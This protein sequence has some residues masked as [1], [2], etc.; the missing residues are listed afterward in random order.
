MSPLRSFVRTLPPSVFA[1]VMATGAISIGAELAGWRAISLVLWGIAGVAWLLL[2][3]LLGIRVFA[4]ARDAL[5]DLDD[6]E[7]GF[8]FFTVVA[9][10]A[11]LG[12][13]TAMAGFTVAAVVLGVLALALWIVLGYGIPW[14]I[15]AS[16][17]RLDEAASSSRGADLVRSV[18]GLWF[19]WVVAAQSVAILATLL[20]PP[21]GTAASVIGL[22]ALIC[23]ATGLG[24]YFVVGGA[25][26]L[27]VLRYGIRADELGPAS[28]VVMGGLAISALA[29]SHLASA[30]GATLDALRPVA[31]GTALTLW[32]C[33]TAIIPALIVLGVWR[34]VV[35]RVSV[36]YTT[37]LWA[38]IFPMGVYSAASLTLGGQ[39]GEPILVQIGVVGVGIALASWVVVCLDFALT[40]ARRT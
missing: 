35:R 39:L 30:H 3:V 28:W 14:R 38:M 6:P 24:L 5:R 17:H 9:A 7:R 31:V 34:H 21:A 8:G 26:A 33:A 13:R 1:F 36:R 16:D 25:F 19:V 12:I 15:V 23:W 29:G 22:L 20:Q 40:R 2:L 37:S 10:T 4:H 11:V 18:D 27:R 32:G